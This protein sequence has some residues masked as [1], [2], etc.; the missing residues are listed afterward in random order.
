M[1]VIMLHLIFIKIVT[2]ICL[3]VQKSSCF[4]HKKKNAFNSV[5]V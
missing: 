2:Q 1:H 3:T 5:L 4:Y